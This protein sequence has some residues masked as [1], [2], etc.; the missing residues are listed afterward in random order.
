VIPPTIGPPATISQFVLKVH[1]RCDLACDHC[2]V[3]E[4]ADQSWRGRPRAIA[5]DTVRA[6][7]DR[8]A[9]HARAHGLTR[10]AVVLHGGEPLLLGARGLRAVTA[11]LRSRI[12]P[13]TT[14][15]LRMQT[16]GILLSEEICDVLAEYDV[17]VGVSLD[18]DRPANDRHRRFA[19]GASSHE[20]VLAGLALLRRPAYRR[21]YAGILCTV[22]V[23]NDPVRVYEALAAEVPPRLDL[24]LPHATWEHPPLRPDGAAT[25]Y[26]DWLLRFYDRWTARG[27][28]MLIR[29]FNAL[30]STAAGGPS[31]SEWV[32]LDP[33]DLVVIE[34]DGAWEQVDSLKTAFDGAPATGMSVFSHAVDDVAR[35]PAIAR[36]QRGLADLAPECRACPVVRQCGGGLFAHRYRPG[37]GFDN[38][39][40]YCADLMELIVSINARSTASSVPAPSAVA[41]LLGRLPEQVGSGRA[42]AEAIGYLAETQL[43]LGRALLVDVGSRGSALGRTALEALGRFERDIPGVV[44]AV[45]GHPYLRVWATHVR[46]QLAEGHHEATSYL[47]CV[48]AAVAVRG[49]RSLVVRVPVDGGA[50]HLPSVGTATVPGPGSGIAELTVEPGTIIVQCGGQRVTIDL[51]AGEQPMWQPSRWIDLQDISVQLEDLDPNRDCHDWKAAGRLPVERVEAWRQSLAAAWQIVRE[52]AP[53]QLPALRLGLHSVTPLEAG[54][55]GLRR[56]S[57]ARDAFGAFGCALAA[58][59]AL[60]EMLVHEFQ[61]TVL[62]ALLDLFDLFDRDHRRHVTVAWRTDPRPIE[63]ALQGTFAHLAVADVWRVRSERAGADT[64]ATETYRRYR[65]WTEAGIDTLVHSNALTPVGVRFVDSMAATVATWSSFTRT[66]GRRRSSPL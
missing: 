66:R 37:N 25:P 55:D 52:E 39:S 17:R 27:R 10:V 8:V 58:P 42:D 38:P 33:A 34:T 41:D 18:G 22:D 9:E 16:N 14:V 56:A 20:R 49:D 3:Y 23:R 30:R 63:G 13:V 48:A 65:E 7:A 59:D 35:L 29:L 4:H 47:G 46:P 24:L 53:F 26:A 12:E 1:S 19:S 57:T 51:A 11:E 15:D 44:R 36:R 5:M 32:G 50:V 40:V 2:Y 28:P 45:L 62:G 64:A 21:Q 31:G 54:S 60:A 6:V 61:H 43:D